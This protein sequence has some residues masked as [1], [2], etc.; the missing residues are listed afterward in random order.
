MKRYGKGEKRSMI[1]AARRTSLAEAAEAYGVPRSTL[2]TWLNNRG[3]YDRGRRGPNRKRRAALP[4]VSSSAK[5]YTAR[6]KAAAAPPAAAPAA[7]RPRLHSSPIGAIDAALAMLQAD[8]EVLRKAGDLLFP[9][10][11]ETPAWDEGAS[12]TITAAYV[13]AE[14]K[15]E[16]LKKARAILAGGEG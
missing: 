3:I 14:E 6:L 7:E 11:K 10:G 9:A 8:A 13:A 2:G 1:A 15:I 5:E 4:K 12:A 16:A